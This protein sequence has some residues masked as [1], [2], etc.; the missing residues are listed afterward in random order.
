MKRIIVVVMGLLLIMCL[1]GCGEKSNVK[2]IEDEINNIS[3]MENSDKKMIKIMNIEKEI[4]K[5]SNK[6]KKG[7]KNLELFY[8]ESKNTS[9]ELKKNV[10][11][12]EYL[13][14]D[15]D[16]LTLNNFV[17]IEN[18]NKISFIKNYSSINIFI[19]KKELINDIVNLIDV[20]YIDKI[21]LINN[22]IDMHDILWLD[23]TEIYFYQ[24]YVNSKFC[25]NIFVYSNGYVRLSVNNENIN[26]T[27][28]S[29]VKIDFNKL[30]D[31]CAY[32]NFGKE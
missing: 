27:Y 32:E 9:L 26:N 8:K 22:D 4:K 18:V 28:V 5:L 24:L 10:S 1:A 16:Y 29:I 23:S 7:I 17:N 11:W 15:V 21:N 12:S 14:M 20:P 19:E 6:E 13:N 31:I 2:T 3:N 30:K 25:M